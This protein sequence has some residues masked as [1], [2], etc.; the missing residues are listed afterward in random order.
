M[1]SVYHVF[2][3]TFVDRFVSIKPPPVKGLSLYPVEISLKSPVN[4][5]SLNTISLVTMVPGF[6][7]LSSGS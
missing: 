1:S 6:L 2:F 3:F 7:P 4:L 5:S